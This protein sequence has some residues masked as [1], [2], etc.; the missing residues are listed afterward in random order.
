[1]L[2]GGEVNHTEFSVSVASVCVTQTSPFY[3]KGLEIL[4]LHICLGKTFSVCT[5]LGYIGAIVSIIQVEKQRGKR[6]RLLF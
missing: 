4:T 3:S 2:E 6:D 5:L 1:M